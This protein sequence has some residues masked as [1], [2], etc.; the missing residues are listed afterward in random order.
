MWTPSLLK[1]NAWNQLKPYYWTAFGAEFIFMMIVG[2]G[3]YAASL[4]PSIFLTIIGEE[5]DSAGYY[6]SIM[7]MYLIMIGL[8]V[9][10]NGFV[11][12]VMETGKSRYF[13][14]ARNGNSDFGN[15][16]WAFQ[17]GRYTKI[18]KIMLWRYLEIMLWSLLFY[19]PGIIKMYEYILVPYL[20]A[21]NPDLSKERAFQISKQ[22]MDG[23]KMACFSFQFSFIGWYLLGVIACGFGIYFVQPY[24]DA[25]M[26]EF[27]ACMRAKMLARGI[28]TESELT[29]Y[30]AMVNTN[31][32]RNQ[33]SNPY[34]QNSYQNQNPVQP[35][36]YQNPYQAQN[37]VQPN[38]Y[39]NPYQAQN[40]VQPNP[41]QNPY[42]AQNPVQQN[43]NFPDPTQ[44]AVMPEAIPPVNLEKEEPEQKPASQI[45]LS[46]ESDTAS[47][48]D[49]TK[50]DDN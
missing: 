38:P 30:S 5:G 7:I 23:E 22:T 26:T 34:E 10:A 45:N 21:E 39:Q 46:K 32:Y 47:K 29:D 13:Y 33:N 27:Y 42:Q 6:F 18:A 19:I 44:S 43:Q 3:S 25:G 50:H 14:Q 16:F 36:P 24:Y 11:T 8:S 9:V 41:Y 2:A 48:I 35:N 1:Q 49:L 40:P 28:A 12:G 37:P 4:V 15:M 20:L 31:P 17:G